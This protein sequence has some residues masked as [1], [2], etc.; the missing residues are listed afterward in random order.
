MTTQP[1]ESLDD[2][3]GTKRGL[4][5]EDRI[6]IAS[7]VRVTCRLVQLARSGRYSHYQEVAE[8]EWRKCGNF[9]GF[10]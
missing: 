1:A 6:A 8:L 4:C 7:R 2:F 10:G 9:G 5:D 3:F